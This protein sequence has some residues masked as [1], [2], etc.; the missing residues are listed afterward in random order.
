VPPSTVTLDIGR[1]FVSATLFLPL[2]ELGTA[3]ALPL[4]GDAS[5]V[6]T[7]YGPTIAEYVRHHM[8]A[9]DRLGR[10]YTLRPLTM[11]LKHTENREWVSNDW[12]EVHAD[13]DAPP[14]SS[15]DFLEL[16]YD[17]IFHRVLSHEVFV[18]V[19]HD[20]RNGLMGDKP[21]LVG[22]LG[23]GSTHVV[24]DGVRG[25]WWFGFRRMFSLGMHHIS[26]G[27][28]HLLFLLELLLPAPWLALAGQWRERKTT[29]AAFRSIVVIAGG[30]TLG[31]C[32]TLAVASAGYVHLP[33]RAVESAIAISILVSSMHAWR[34]IFP[35]REVWIAFAFGLVHGL[36]FATVL[37]GLSFDGITLAVALAG[38][39]LGIEW[40][41]LLLIAVVLPILLVLS[42]T[43]AY[44]V[45]RNAGA[46]VGAACALGWI[47]ERGF[48]L[49]NPLR[50][51]TDWLAA[52]TPWAIATALGASGVSLAL[53]CVRGVVARQHRSLAL[54]LRDT[55]APAIAG[56]VQE[57]T[58]PRPTTDLLPPRD[59]E[60]W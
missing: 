41:Q 50:A 52:F 2:S 9:K 51:F 60:G 59:R 26:E 46:A 6:P 15:T 16:D 34:P 57:V 37:T 20:L 23:F 30:F 45:L 36:A 8:R 40:M 21:Q 1:R 25:S 49:S 53:L 55:D 14:E 13:F 27:T 58:R 33:S 43:R 4:A 18:Y 7:R 17:V 42:A 54:S 35:G 48:L 28:D 39:N 44:P 24:V 5:S 31:H 3:L 47:A 19:S 12:L 32:L 11:D 38:F 22:M 56:L 10:A 29:A